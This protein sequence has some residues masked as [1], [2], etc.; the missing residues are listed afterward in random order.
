MVAVGVHGW[1]GEGP[2]TVV[3][4]VRTSILPGRLLYTKQNLKLGKQNLKLAQSCNGC[5]SLCQKQPLI[6]GGKSKMTWI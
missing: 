4:Q 5:P 6:K 2:S 3:S 1:T